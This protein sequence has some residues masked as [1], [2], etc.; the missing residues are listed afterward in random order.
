MQEAV[1][2]LQS[3][4]QLLQGDQGL[5]STCN[6]VPQ[7]LQPDKASDCLPLHLGECLLVTVTKVFKLGQVPLRQRNARW[8]LIGA[9]E[10]ESVHRTL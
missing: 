7:I 2:R 3:K 9:F 1:H 4:D 10:I 8:R 6:M 5:S